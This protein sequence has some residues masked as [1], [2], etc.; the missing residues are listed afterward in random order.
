MPLIGWMHFISYCWFSK[1][2][3]IIHFTGSY[4][5]WKFSTFSHIWSQVNGKPSG[6][7]QLSSISLSGSSIGS[8][9]CLFWFLISFVS[10]G[11]H[12]NNSYFL[13]SS[14]FC[15]SNLCSLIAI[16]LVV[17]ISFK[18]NI[19]IE[20]IYNDFNWNWR[21]VSLSGHN[22]NKYCDGFFR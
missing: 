15:L 7:G 21:W 19:F 9:G 6:I 22:C 13:N 3:Q 5:R 10:I 2:F 8:M 16:F 17:Q 11:S 20:K 18:Q 14:I 1:M 12:L 4:T